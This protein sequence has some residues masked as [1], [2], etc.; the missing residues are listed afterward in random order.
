[1]YTHATYSEW[2]Y[3]WPQLLEPTLMRPSRSITRQNP[4]SLDSHASRE[5]RNATSDR[6]VNMT[7]ARSILHLTLTLSPSAA[8]Y[9]SLHSRSYLPFL[10]SSPASSFSAPSISSHSL[11][12]ILLPEQPIA[13]S[14]NCLTLY[15]PTISTSPTVRSPNSPARSYHLHSTP[16]I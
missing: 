2:V 12:A 15:L 16:D 8:I 11:P 1:M 5:S 6:V 3:P 4:L 9:C 13:D 10:H 7:T 14:P